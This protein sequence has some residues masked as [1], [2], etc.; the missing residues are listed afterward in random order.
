MIDPSGI[1]FDR[2]PSSRAE[3]KIMALTRQIDDRAPEFSLP[4]TDGR[5]YSVQSFAGPPAVVVL[6]TC[7]TCPFVLGSNEVTLRATTE[8]GPAAA[9]RP[10]R[11]A[12]E[13]FSQEAFSSFER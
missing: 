8:C 10:A 13:P 3:E 7:N 1:P 4:A 9:T 2:V 11:A 12:C 6:F 5:P